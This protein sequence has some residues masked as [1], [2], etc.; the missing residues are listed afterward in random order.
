MG[1]EKNPW[2]TAAPVVEMRCGQHRGA[3]T[4]VT[5]DRVAG[6]IA[7]D[8]AR[9]HVPIASFNVRPRGCTCLSPS[10]RAK[11]NGTTE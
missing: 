9:C 1:D 4:I 5:F 11:V 2:A 8:C 7:L 6:T 3:A 10:Q